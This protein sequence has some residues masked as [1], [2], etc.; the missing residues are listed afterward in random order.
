[1]GYVEAALAAIG[2]ELVVKTER[3]ELPVT[4]C[5]RPLY[6][7]GTCRTKDIWHA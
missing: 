7:K 1:M 4:V 2:T 5:P 6:D 3:A